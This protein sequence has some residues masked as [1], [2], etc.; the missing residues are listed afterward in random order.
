MKSLKKKF[1]R[2]PSEKVHLLND[3]IY[4]AAQSPGP[5]AYFRNTGATF[6][7]PAK[8]AKRSLSP[9][10]IARKIK[11]KQIKKDFIR[12]KSPDNR[13]YSPLPLNFF[14]FERFKKDILDDKSKGKNHKKKEEKPQFLFIGGD[15]RFRYPEEKKGFDPGP[16]PDAYK[17]DVKW[18]Q[19]EKARNSS[20]NGKKEK[21]NDKESL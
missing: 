3:E 2:T 19:K 6:S 21:E 20:K 12:S 4:L 13:E 1:S 9:D 18:P 7:F 17:I 15:K 16:G 8:K 11:Q 14:T 5:G 10:E